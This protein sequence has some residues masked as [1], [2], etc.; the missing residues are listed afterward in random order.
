MTGKFKNV[1][2]SFIWMTV[3][4]I[5]VFCNS[6]FA[7]DSG[8]RNDETFFAAG[9][10]DWEY[11]E[12]IVNDAY[13]DAVKY[14]A[15]YAFVSD[16]ETYTGA[17]DTV[18]VDTRFYNYR[19]N[20]G[21]ADMY[22][23]VYGYDYHED[24]VA[25]VTIYYYS[26]SDSIV[27][28]FVLADDSVLSASDIE[29][30]RLRKYENGLKELRLVL[31]RKAL[32]DL[33]FFSRENGR[34]EVLSPTSTRGDIIVSCVSF[35]LSRGDYGVIRVIDGE[36]CILTA[37][38]EIRSRVDSGQPVI[39][40]NT[41]ST[42]MITA[43]D[44][45][46]VGVVCCEEDYIVTTRG[47]SLTAMNYSDIAAVGSTSDSAAAGS[48]TV[49]VGT[50]DKQDCE[51]DPD[52]DCEET[53][54]QAQESLDNN[55]SDMADDAVSD[56]METDIDEYSCFCPDEGDASA[57][58]C[59]SFIFAENNNPYLYEL[60]PSALGTEFF[61]SI[62]GIP[63]VLSLPETSCSDPLELLGCN[64]G[65]IVPASDSMVLTVNGGCVSDYA[66]ELRF[67][68]ASE[69]AGDIRFHKADGTGYDTDGCMINMTEA[70]LKKASY[71][72][73]DA[74]NIV[75]AVYNVHGRLLGLADGYY[76]EDI[77]G[78]LLLPVSGSG[79][80]AY[81]KEV[82][83][84]YN[85][86]LAENGA[87]VTLDYYDGTGETAA[88]AACMSGFVNYGDTVEIELSV[89]TD[90]GEC[91]YS[92]S[93]E[94]IDVIF[95]GFGEYDIRCIS[96]REL[97]DEA[98]ENAAAEPEGAGTDTAGV[99]GPPQENGSIT[100]G[101]GHAADGPGI[102]DGE[103]A[104]NGADTGASEAVEDAEGTEGQ[105]S[106]DDPESTHDTDTGGDQAG[107]DVTDAGGGQ[108][109][110]DVTDT[111][112]GQAGIV[113]T[114]TPGSPGDSEDTA[115]KGSTA[116]DTGSGDPSGKKDTAVT[117]GGT[118]DDGNAFGG[119]S[120]AAACKQ[121]VT[122]Q[123]DAGTAENTASPPVTDT[124]PDT[125]PDAGSPVTDTGPYT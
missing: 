62:F 44:T 60:T 40:S 113:D 11:I 114:D 70:F 8:C 61:G 35:S 100:E 102:T 103:G 33:A 51:A 16:G 85:D 98:D 84:Q 95:D 37:D 119:Q 52:K 25:E 32:S 75:C 39:Y 4:L 29:G 24:N 87:Y 124:G 90:A 7:A 55:E 122:A 106:I 112:G 92:V 108:T 99:S 91:S 125:G 2:L 104:G 17:A 53:F 26:G 109:G 3:L 20:I 89:N 46:K 111:G 101:T 54:D 71:C 57:V 96:C 49:T 1:R 110:T 27:P 41:G 115:G 64:A 88:F 69:D 107:T 5:L 79:G 65:D 78:F 76:E 43:A 73:V 47:R 58:Y 123:P 56:I 121:Q 86:L 36:D 82:S 30:A 68:A 9:E 80:D 83:V 18:P 72:A 77:A 38:A 34:V 81:I 67:A 48:D 15:D 59:D 13:G 66:G 45:D 120:G 28:E 21:Q 10:D 94:D 42:F 12:S 6:A 50:D 116:D 22:I 93:D 97:E 31:D 74:D 14:R 63:G 117:A 23:G 105:E 19:Y 118:G